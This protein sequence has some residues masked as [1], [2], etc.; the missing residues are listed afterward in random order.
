[1]TN[2]IIT[3]KADRLIGPLTLRARVHNGRVVDTELLMAGRVWAVD[4]LL[5]HERAWYDE[6]LAEVKREAA[7]GAA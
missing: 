6:A 1:M 5:R 3:L 7:G 2:G 4:Q